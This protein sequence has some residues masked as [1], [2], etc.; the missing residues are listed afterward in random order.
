MGLTSSFLQYAPDLAYISSFLG[1]RSGY[2]LLETGTGSASA[3][4]S[5]A[6]TVGPEGRIYTFENNQERFEKNVEELA[7]L[8]YNDRV[9]CFHRD[10]YAEGF[11]FNDGTGNGVA[12]NSIDGAFIDL[13]QPWRVLDSLHETLKDQGT[14]AIFSPCSEQVN[15][16]AKL[17]RSK[18]YHGVEC[19]E[20]LCKGWNCWTE[21]D[22]AKR[23]HR[24]ELSRKANLEAGRTSKA[25][26][27][28]VIKN[29]ARFNV[30]NYVLYQ[31]E[32]RGHTGYILTATKPPS[33]EEDFENPKSIQC[34]F[35]AHRN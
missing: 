15:E 5:F 29:E 28:L 10:V 19:V 31:L 13:P 3:T 26:E 23:R 14:V 18:D 7:T 12:A 8:G 27:K 30:R 24:A 32:S 11:G 1:L 34:K 35:K 20:V 9:V 16:C 4:V 2:R 25:V 17:L 21:T 6:R 33:D 22:S